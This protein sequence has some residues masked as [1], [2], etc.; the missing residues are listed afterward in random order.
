[1]YL[2]DRDI[3]G[4][5]DEMAIAGPNPN[6]PFEADRQ[7]QPCSVDLRV[8]DV[9]WR[10]SRR[11]RLWRR[12]LPGREITVDLRRSDVHDLD[13]LRDWKR[14]DVSE[15]QSITIKPGHILMGRIYERFRVPPGYAGKVEGRSSYARLGLAV[16]CTGDFINPGWEGY[17][18]LQLCNFGPY[19]V[20]IAP[21]FSICQLMLVRLSSVSER[22]Y[23]D[24]ELKS[25]YINDDGG[26]SLWWRDARV[27]QLQERLG[28][29]D[30]AE[31]IRQEIVDTVRFESPQVLER[32]QR[33]I[34]HK[35][36]GA[37][38]NTHQVLDEFARTEGRRR[39]IDNAALA[40]P[41]LFAGGAI[42]S[43]FATFSAWT[44]VLIVATVVASL[45]A[46]GAYVR[47][48]SGYLGRPELRDAESRPKGES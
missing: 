22:S 7:I 23:G 15:G 14:I 8:S 10:P 9:F 16:H 38:E 19:P 31:G 5:L 42:G 48:D 36:A 47:R 2:A 12:L 1:M 25:K 43:V 11:R 33:H 26:P 4:L 37:I 17:M 13:P 3:R 35:K 40:L 28:A 18:P 45:A 30:V 29:A 24:A 39:M 41:L 21:Y 44:V 20:R 46:F 6:H 34:D 32:L 27:R